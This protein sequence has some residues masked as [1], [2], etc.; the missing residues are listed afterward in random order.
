MK[1]LNFP[2]WALHTPVRVYKVING[3]DGEE[4]SQIFEGLCN[5]SEKPKTYLTANQRLVRLSGRGIFKGPLNDGQKFKG[6]L[7]LI[8]KSGN[9]KREIANIYFTR[10][11]DGSIFSTEVE[12][13]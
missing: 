9:E 6:Y 5:F 7:E 2:D 12:L 1:I 4:T 10:N 3:E 13:L 11:T 8:K